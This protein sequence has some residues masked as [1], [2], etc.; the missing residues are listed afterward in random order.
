MKFCDK[1]S[2]KQ[3]LQLNVYIIL[4][5]TKCTNWENRLRLNVMYF[6]KG[7]VMEP[8]TCLVH[9]NNKYQTVTNSPELLD[10]SLV[11][12]LRRGIVIIV[13]DACMHQRLLQRLFCGGRHPI[14]SVWTSFIF[15]GGQ[16]FFDVCIYRQPVGYPH[17]ISS[18]YEDQL[19]QN[20]SPDIYAV[21]WLF[22]DCC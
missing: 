12:V 11:L 7:I 8:H 5:N 20:I 3:M 4:P 18:V 10:Y 9:A 19:G 14:D 13:T 2:P 1:S 15:S 21:M 22:S 6:D 16:R 17:S